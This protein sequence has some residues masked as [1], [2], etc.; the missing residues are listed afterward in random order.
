MN[1]IGY[2]RVSSE[3]QAD[4]GLGLDAQRFTI[5]QEADRR[6]WPLEIVEDAGFT[7][8]NMRRPALNE[9]LTRLDNCQTRDQPCLRERAMKLDRL[10]RSLQDFASIMARSRKH[11][12]SLVCLDLGVDTSTAQ[13]RM[14]ANIFATLAEWESEMIGERTSNALQAKKRQGV[15]L[16]RPRSVCPEA[17]NLIATRRLHGDS[18][19]AI[20]ELLT[21]HGIPTAQG[22]KWHPETVRQIDQREAA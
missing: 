18:Y 1:A 3:Q 10:S 22:G 17:V 19:A 6:G 15:K 21:R 20:A 2:V 7:G 4:S 13:G 11:G 12:W 14:V 5:Q 16:G 9:I 8:R